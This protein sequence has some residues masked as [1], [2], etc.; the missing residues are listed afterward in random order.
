MM[1]QMAKE[2]GSN[3]NEWASRIGALACFCENEH[4]A[5]VSHDK[6]Y[7]VYDLDGNPIYV[8]VCKDWEEYTHGT[9]F[10]LNQTF[11]QFIV[12][13]NYFLRVF[14]IYLA[15]LIRYKRMSMEIEFIKQS[16]FYVTFFNSGLLM[17][18]ASADIR[19]GGFATLIFSGVYTDVNSYWF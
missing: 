12:L 10:W 7:S 1:K 6:V 18:I 4:A 3:M 19:S 11:G 17:L 14:F 2:A 13:T 5:G 8:A 15:S 9:A 16:V